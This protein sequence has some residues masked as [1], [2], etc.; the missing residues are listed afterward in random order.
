MIYNESEKQ[1]P[2]TRLI[3]RGFIDLLLF[4]YFFR[5]LIVFPLSNLKKYMPS[6]KSL[7]SID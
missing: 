4:N 7:T 6:E 1:K 3:V 2:L 5:N